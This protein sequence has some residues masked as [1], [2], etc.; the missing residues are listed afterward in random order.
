[1]KTLF[2]SSS[3]VKYYL[4]ETGSSEVRELFSLSKG[5]FFSSILL[6]EVYST[7]GR[8]LRMDILTKSQYEV[9]RKLIQKDISALIR[10]GI[11][12]EIW[13]ISR[14]LTMTYNLRAMDAIH[15]ASA[16][17]ANVDLFVTS[18]KRQYEA[19]RSAKI[20]SRFI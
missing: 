12:V 15:I 16:A 5:I 2:D 17:Y 20:E 13:E 9:Y 14:I 10:V 3:F 19:A 11:N 6:V 4:D 18:D 1:L 8:G 7:I